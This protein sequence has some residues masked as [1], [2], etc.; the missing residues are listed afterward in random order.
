MVENFE[1]AYFYYNKT[2]NTVKAN[3]I[4]KLFMIIK[5]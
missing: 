3:E 2:G 4:L 5:K 1:K